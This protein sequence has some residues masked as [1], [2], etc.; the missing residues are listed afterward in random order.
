MELT[1]DSK[2]KFLVASKNLDTLLFKEEIYWAQRS[3]I[4]WLKHGDKNTRF[5]HLKASQRKQRNH[6]QSIKNAED[7]WVEEESDIAGVALEYFETLFKAGTCER[8][9]ECLNGVNSKITPDMQQVLSSMFCAEEVKTALFQMGPTKAP[10]PDG[11]NALFYQKFWHVVGDMVVNAV[12]DFLNSG[13]MVPE[14]NSTYIVLID[15]KS[16]V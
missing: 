7:V 3:R 2:A 12:L 6:I 13:H 1:E 5:F 16:V 8:L 4:P 14:I 9:E 15:R 10:G 11:M